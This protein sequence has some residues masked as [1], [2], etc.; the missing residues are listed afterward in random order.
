MLINH[1]MAT[2]QKSRIF[3]DLIASYSLYSSHEHVISVEP[4]QHADVYIHHR[5]NK[6]KH[7]PNK[8]LA[9]IHHDLSDID[10]AFSL[11]QYLVPTRKV[12]GVICLNSLQ[13]QILQDQSVSSD[14]KVI[15]HGY[16]CTP[17]A[18]ETFNSIRS[19]KSNNHIPS[20]HLKTVLFINSRRYIRGVKGESSLRMLTKDL[21]TS[22]FEFHLCGKDRIIDAIFIRNSGFTVLFHQPKHYIDTLKLY[23]CP[24]LLLNLSWYEG[25][26]ANLPEAIY[27]GVPV[28]TR[29]IG[30]AHDLFDKDYMGFFSNYEGLQRII[31]S[32]RSSEHFREELLSQT[33]NS[34]EKLKSQADVGMEID[35]FCESLFS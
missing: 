9:F 1:V 22:A 15:A 17:S 25:G 20:Q 12:N 28:I 23:R 7:I 11:K 14:I 35:K 4:L 29:R 8:S 21:D 18:L 24:D 30:M 5:I 31:A 16:A 13:K 32:W 26:P 33:R 3:D 27:A 10:P 34:A 2:E 19:G 6:S